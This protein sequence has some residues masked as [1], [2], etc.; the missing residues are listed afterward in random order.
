MDGSLNDQALSAFEQGLT[1]LAHDPAVKTGYFG[2]PAN[3]HRDVVENSY[4]YGLVLVFGS[5][6]DHNHYQ[7]GQVHQ[8]FIADHSAKWEKVVVFD[9]ETG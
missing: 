2:P 6:A 7:V 3:T 4:T 9:I 5:I 1:A 8:Q